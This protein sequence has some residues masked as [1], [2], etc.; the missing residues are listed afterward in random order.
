MLFTRLSDILGPEI[1]CPVYVSKIIDFKAMVFQKF[2]N[3]LPG[4]APVSP[5]IK[6]VNKTVEKSGGPVKSCPIPVMIAFFKATNK[7]CFGRQ[8]S[9]KSM[10][11]ALKM[12]D[13]VKFLKVDQ[14][15]DPFK[16]IVVVVIMVH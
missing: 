15:S 10:K 9:I 7:I 1:G 13:L 4:Q 2:C 8:N 16:V 11:K 6:N 3:T 5:G 14:S 12:P